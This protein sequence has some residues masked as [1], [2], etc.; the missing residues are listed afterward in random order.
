M[1]PS[2]GL[3]YLASSLERAGH[4]V[5]ILDGMRERLVPADLEPFLEGRHFDVAGFQ[6]FTCDLPQVKE[7]I[8]IARRRLPSA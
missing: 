2:L 5:T 1:V 4:R 3:G 7:L 6:S 8:G